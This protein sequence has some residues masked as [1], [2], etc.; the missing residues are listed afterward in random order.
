MVFEFCSG[1]VDLVVGVGHNLCGG[2]RLTL[3]GE[4]FVGRLA[5][6]V[7]EVG[8]RGAELGDPEVISEE[9]R[10]SMAIRYPQVGGSCRRSGPWLRVFAD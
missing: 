8:D 10:D 4:R 5:E 6:D 3:A 9:R 1:L 7:A 2:H